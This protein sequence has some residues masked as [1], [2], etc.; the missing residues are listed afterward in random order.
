[1]VVLERVQ[2][3]L[4]PGSDE[5]GLGLR[6][7][8]RDQALFGRDGALRGDDDECLVLRLVHPDR[9]ALVGLL[10]H[11]RVSR[12]VAPEAVAPHLERAHGGVRPGV[13]ERLVVG[14]EGETVVGAFDLVRQILTGLEIPHLDDHELAPGE[15]G[16]PGDE[17]VVGADGEVADVEVRLAL[18]ELVLV[19]DDDLVAVRPGRRGRRRADAPPAEEGVIET[20]DGT[21]VVR[22]LPLRGRE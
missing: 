16:R 3:A 15:V 4:A 8:R 11:E 13:E 6:P 20:L 5:K 2:D 1:M 14:G 17:P 19:E 10:E 18:R 21:R 9:E 7:V 22:P 12:R